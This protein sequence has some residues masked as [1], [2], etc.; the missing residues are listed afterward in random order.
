M[1]FIKNLEDS[2]LRYCGI[3]K[4]DSLDKNK[5]VFLFLLVYWYLQFTGVLGHNHP[6]IIEYAQQLLHQR[7]PIHAQMSVRTKAADLAEALSRE[8]GKTTGKAYV[9]TFANSGDEA[10]EAAAKHARMV[11]FQAQDAVL[12]KIRVAVFGA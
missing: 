7:I 2:G 8:I 1:E 6:E 12:S 5:V 4:R 3:V 10:V 11:F 9:T